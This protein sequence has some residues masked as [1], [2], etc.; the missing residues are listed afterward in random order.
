MIIG[1]KTVRYRTIDST[2]TAARRLI[3]QGEG[4]GL[5]VQAAEQTAGRGKP[6]SRWASPPGNLY[7]S[8]VVRPFRNQRELAPLTLLAALAARQVLQ[9]YRPVTVVIKWPNDL[10]VRGRKIGGILTERLASGHVIIGIGLNLNRLPS[11]VK[12]SA[13]SLRQLTG[14]KVSPE[15]VADRLNL[16]LDK[17]YRSFLKRS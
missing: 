7:Y 6:G 9:S 17:E 2:N 13:I 4:E 12:A 10:L 11:A 5:V 8:A 16:A 3:G 1:K 14:K 15:A